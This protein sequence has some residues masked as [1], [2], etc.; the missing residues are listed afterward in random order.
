MIDFLRSEISSWKYIK[1]C[2]VPV[3]MYGMG[4]GA[5]HIIRR[6]ESDKITVSDFFAS[7]EFVRGQSFHGKHVKRLS[8][9]EK[10]YDDFIIVVAFGTQRPEVMENIKAIAARHKVIVP[11]VPVFGDNIFDT[12]FITNNEDKILKALELF[13]EEKS[14][15]VYKEII[16]FS[17][18]GRLEYLF[19]SESEKD[20]VFE[21]VLNLSGDE[22]YLD[23][24]AYRGDTVDEFLKYTNGLYKSIT[25]LEPD[26]KTY[27]KLIEHCGELENFTALNAAVW[28]NECDIYFDK[29]GGRMSAVSESGIK[30]NGISVDTLNSEKNFSYI[31]AD[32]EGCEYKALLGAKNTLKKQ[33]PKLNIALYHRGE[34]IFK[35]PLMIKDIRPD[36][37]FYFRHH[38]YIPAWDTNLYCI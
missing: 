17:Y 13:E 19:A 18:S 24:G 26:P 6:L 23:L 8:D 14:R 12:D 15:E 35:L 32:V 34:D 16:K 1:Q 27:K 25:A 29:K 5:D 30:I 21:N 38:P 11:T 9:I 37:K 3:I 4:N 20:E 22:S 36:Y 31:K 10:E 2:G 28:N 33:K 7:D